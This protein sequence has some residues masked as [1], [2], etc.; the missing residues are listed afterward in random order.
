MTNLIKQYPTI[1][2]WILENGKDASNW[3]LDEAICEVLNDMEENGHHEMSA[4]QSMTSNPLI[5]NMT[6]I[7]AEERP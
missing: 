6:D 4:S 7:P 2:K 3:N 5:L 1:S